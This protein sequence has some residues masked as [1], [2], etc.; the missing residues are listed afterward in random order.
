MTR[1]T[2]IE[3]PKSATGIAGF[4]DI[5]LGGLPAGRPTLVCGAAGCGKTLFG[6][7]FLVNGAT[8]FGEPGVFMSFEERAE[9]LAANVA[10]LGYDL[11][12]LVATGKLAIDHVRVERSEI[13]E[14]G[15]YDL[16]GLFVRL[17]YAVDSVGARRVVLDTIESL[18][19][20][21]TDTAILRAELRRLFAWI[22]DRGLTA[23]VTGERGE[24]QLTRQ[25][26]E[27]YIS[28]C[29]ILLDNRVVDQVTTR[30]LRVVKYRGSAHGTNEYPF[31]IDE[32][33]ISVLPVTSSGIE[34]PVS[35]EIISAGI[36]GL[37]AMLRNGGFYRGSSILLSGVAGTGK[38]TIGGHFVNAACK[39]GERCMI[40][41]F[42][43]G[44]DEICRNLRSVGLD[45]RQWVEAGLLRFEAARPSLYGLEMH[46]ARMHR[47]LNR[48]DP[49]VVVVDPI[50]ALRGPDVEVHTT[51]L[52]MVDLLKSRGITGLFTSLRAAGS[53]HDGTDQAISSLMDSWIR[54]LDVEA[55][56]ER[57]RVLYVIKSRGTSHSNQVREFRMTDGGIELIDPYVG[58]EGVLTGAA[59]LSQEAREHAAA[60]RRRHEIAQRGRELARRRD[61]LERQ[62]KE[63]QATLD[64]D[65]DEAQALL[66]E[67]QAQDAMLAR[68]SAAIAA[69]RG[70]AE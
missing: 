70:S 41:A 57:N 56:G 68:N 20:G 15:Q 43:E 19:S 22:K 69:R 6:V 61:A 62:V 31:L 39:R 4:D 13:E 44:A 5:L 59:R 3:L 14:T 7:T 32:G 50:S 12:D 34:R 2:A 23:I 38:T 10:S 52:R 46:L 28:D 48:F 42:E 55:N 35:E 51:L 49:S 65:Q 47:D 27:E 60:E 18:F 66:I 11:D 40:F 21:F 24:G 1:P 54:L 26:L 30:R 37:D 36:A 58:P 64:A 45:L 17:G 8:R 33:G 16:E 25:G 63:L 67:E 53:L 9:D 29:V